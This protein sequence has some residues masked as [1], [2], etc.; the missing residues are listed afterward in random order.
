VIFDVEKVEALMNEQR[1]RSGAGF[2]WKHND[3]DG[4]NNLESLDGRSTFSGYE[5]IEEPDVLITSCCEISGKSWITIDPCPFYPEGGGQIS[6]TGT[7]TDVDTGEIFQVKQCT[8]L[9]GDRIALML[10]HPVNVGK[11]VSACVNQEKRHGSSIHHT[12]T[13]LLNAGLRKYVNG[14]IVQAGS[15][16][17][18]DKLRFDFTHS[19][20]LTPEMVSQIEG[21][22][23]S[24]SIQQLPVYTTIMSLEQAKEANAM[25]LFGEKY[26]NTV[27]VVGVGQRANPE[28]L[29]LCGGTHVSSLAPLFPFK[30]VSETSAASGTRRIEAVAGISAL[31]WL[32]DKQRH[33]EKICTNLNVNPDEAVEMVLKMKTKLRQQEKELLVLKTTDVIGSGGNSV[34]IGNVCVHVIDPPENTTKKAFAKIIQS[35]ANS[36]RE[37]APESWHFV[38]CG[39]LLACTV[40]PFN[41]DVKA[42]VVSAHAGKMLRA[43][44]EEIGGKGGGNDTFAQGILENAN[45]N[46][47]EIAH[48]AKEIIEV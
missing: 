38:K 36:K 34:S 29:E 10:D 11:R 32:E 28:S 25:M 27:R 31:R 44:F 43:L 26:E 47:N 14:A 2:S 37:G 5:S 18:S 15:L 13:H 6:D 46:S 16:V 1:I 45:L 39:N 7:L 24:L 33:L 20:P 40:D 41:P 4:L 8:R 48:A 35:Y 12:A 19:K 23:N 42:G 21:Y 9:S 3:A 22:I 17:T 30:I